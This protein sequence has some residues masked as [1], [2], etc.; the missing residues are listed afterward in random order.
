MA[1]IRSKM[2]R[3]L[4][5][6]LIGIASLNL[7]TGGP[8]L[9]LWIGSRTQ[10]S[11]PPTMTGLLVVTIVLLAVSLA[12]IRLIAALQAAYNKHSGQMPGIRAHAPWLRSMRG[13]RPL[14]PGERARITAPE[15]ILVI[16][17][18]IAVIAFE[19][20]FIFVSG[21]PID[22]RSGRGDVYP[23]PV[24]TAIANPSHPLLPTV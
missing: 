20:W 3:V 18:M 23:S 16:V 5:L 24:T 21:S 6:S 10:G 2:W 12:L 8:L 17:V 7:W 11:G 22:Q 1:Q 13:E 9:A 19:I 15:R 14:Y 4:L